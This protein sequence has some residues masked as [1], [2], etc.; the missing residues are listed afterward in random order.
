MKKF[1]MICVAMAALACAALFAQPEKI[2]VV[3][4]VAP[5]YNIV[6]AIA[7]DRVNLVLMVPSG[8]SPHTYSPK[9]S[10]I[11]NLAASDLYFGAGAGLEFWAEKMIKASGSTKLVRINMTDGVK[12]IAEEEHGHGEHGHE[13]GNPHVWLNPVIAA[14][15]AKKVSA[16]LS[17]KDPS[18]AAYYAA[19][20]K[21]FEK[22]TTVLDAD[23]KKET[24]ALTKK[25]FVA[26]HPS[27]V[28]FAEHYGLNQA[29]VIQST[30][31][32]NPTP[33]EMAQVVDEIKKLGIGAVFAEP[34]LPKKAA[35]VI[36]KEAG[37]KVLV[38]DPYGTAGEEYTEFIKRN[39]EIIKQTLK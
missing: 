21:K 34:Q 12:L 7:R 32:K 36:A 16:A 18:N 2:T 35:E 8:A 1:L 26:F 5:V 6:K 24:A 39:F 17:G 25:D 13:A 38:L 14:G 11:K 9:P 37:V 3:A 31:G 19:N 29:A 10:S 27:W 30:P 28:Y 23:V 4:S 22:E 33:K 20:L 15:F